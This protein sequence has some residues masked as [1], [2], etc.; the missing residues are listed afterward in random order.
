MRTR[1]FL[2]DDSQT[3]RQLLHDVFTEAG[4]NVCGD[5]SNGRE[6][7]EK[8]EQLKPDVVLVD[9]IMP[10]LNGVE[11]VSALRKVLPA[12]TFIVLMTLHEAAIGTAMCAGFA[13]DLVVSK[14]DGVNA[15]VH[16]IQALVTGSADGILFGAEPEKPPPR[17][18]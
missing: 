8:A 13:A 5:A 7:V 6:L 1:I 15:M 11:A 2:A 17:V 16:K 10:K 18:Q 4:F 12:G 3:V 14:F 9:I